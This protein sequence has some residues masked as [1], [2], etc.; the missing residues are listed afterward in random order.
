MAISKLT[1]I[2]N[3]TDADDANLRDVLDD[4]RLAAVSVRLLLE[5]PPLN[6]D[7]ILTGMRLVESHMAI[8]Y[9]FKADRQG[10]TAGYPSEPI[11]AEA[12]AQVMW[13]FRRPVS[14]VLAQYVTSGMVPIGTRGELVMRLL[15]IKAF[16]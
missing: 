10:L 15:L 12:A 2:Y 8:A 9:T 5:Y 4:A 3:Y 6:E 7:F 14:E 13:K 1:G 11:V 16:D